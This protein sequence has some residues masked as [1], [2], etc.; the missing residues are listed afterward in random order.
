MAS[1]VAERLGWRLIDNELIDE[2]AERAGLPAEKVARQQERAPSF[3]E[4]LASVTAVQL[5]ELFMSPTINEVA[6]E[7]R[8]AQITGSVVDELA[9]QGHCVLVGRASAAVCA[10][11]QDALLVRLVGTVETRLKHALELGVAAEDAEAVL[12]ETDGNRARYHR[13]YYDRD[14]DDPTLYDLVLNTSRLGFDEA[15]EVVVALAAR[16]WGLTLGSVR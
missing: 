16:R 14:W 5:P 12:N 11:R 9:N 2:V 6:E 7:A 4:R 3:I 1:A 15:T 8:L 10:D 13:Q